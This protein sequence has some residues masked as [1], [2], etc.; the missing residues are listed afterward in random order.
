[1]RISAA[2]RT[3]NENRIRAAMDRLLRGEIPPGGKCDIKTLASEAAVDRTAFY[4]SRPYAH[5]RLEFE[6]RV[7]ALRDAGE[8]PDPREAQ[9]ARLKAEVAKLKERLAQSEQ[10]ID[11]LTDFRSQALA[12][13]TAQ[14]EEI[15]HLRETAAGTGRVTRLPAARSATFGSCS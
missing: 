12:R 4:G 15:V 3:E 7:Q 11:E 5:L 13:L 1:M 9:I 2:Q 14:H 10:T 6:R 8:I